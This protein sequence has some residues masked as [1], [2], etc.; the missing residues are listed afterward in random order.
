MKT[1]EEPSANETFPIISLPEDDI[2]KS[3]L[4]LFTTI[5]VSVVI[6]ILVIIDQLLG[7]WS[8]G[9]YWILFSLGLIFCTIA[10]WVVLQWDEGHRQDGR[11][12][13]LEKW[14]DEI[15]WP[16]MILAFTIQFVLPQIRPIL[17]GAILGGSWLLV[18]R[19]RIS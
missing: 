12:T 2:S 16:V 11:E 13:V 7:L 10:I 4:R 3:R 5:S 6:V 19:E 1:E 15:G 18:I 14:G 9:V 17:L 8:F